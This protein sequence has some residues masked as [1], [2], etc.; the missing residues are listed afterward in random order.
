MTLP[1][2]PSHHQTLMILLFFHKLR[3]YGKFAKITNEAT[4]HY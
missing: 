2:E 3:E 4:N 1:S